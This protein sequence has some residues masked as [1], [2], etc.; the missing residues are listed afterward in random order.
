MAEPSPKNATPSTFRPYVAPGVIMPEFTTRAV[1]LGAILGV[2]FGAVS[3][4]LAL[5]A[6]LTVSASIPVAVLS[7][8]I[9]KWLGKST[10]L[11]NNMVQTV[12]S[13]GESIA[14]GVAFTLPALIFLGFQLDYWNVFLLALAGGL[15]G[16]LFVVPLR[17][18]LVVKEH[19]NLLFPEGKA[20]ADV[21]ISGEEKG[22]QAGKVFIGAGLGLVYKF[23]MGETGGLSFW[24]A[25]P[26][27]HPRWY[28]GSTLAGEITPEYLGVGYIIGP[29][30][31][32][33]MFAGGVISWLVLIPIIKFFG[34]HIPEAIYPGTVPISQM[35]PLDVWRAY[36][37]YIGAGAVTMAG[38]ITLGRTLPTIVGSFRAAFKQLAQSRRGAVVSAERTERDLPLSAVLI[39]T[40]I[41]IV[42]VWALLAFHINPGAHGN[43]VS[44]ILIV[45]F[46]FFFA[47]V[48]ARIVG[49]IGSSS[50][51]VSGMTI[52]TLMFTCLIFVVVGWTGNVYSSIALSI[53]GVICIAAACAGAT[54]QS[55]KTGYLVGGTPSRQEIG[56]L[57]GVLTSVL[58]VGVTLKL[59]NKSAT[60]VNPMT[61]ANVTVTPDMKPQG[62]INYQ[63]REFQVL[64]VIG[65]RTVP[66]GRYYYDPQNR[67]IDYQEVEGI[68]SLDYPAPQATLMSVVINGILNRRLPWSLVLF[69]AFIV[70]TLELCGVRSLAFAVGSYLPISTTAPIFTGGLVKWLVQRVTKTT[71]EES[72]TGAGALFS[73]GLIAGGALGGLALA[74]VVGLKKAEAVAV[75][76]RWFPAFA[77]S[78]LAALL[79][80]VGLATLLFF[81]AKSKKP[82]TK[83]KQ[84]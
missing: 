20:C 69:G 12:G 63:G 17:P 23:L 61:I 75:G 42:M 49:L 11:E 21:L 79:I 8:S 27:W 45:I 40:G 48:S 24:K 41:M 74:V 32:G 36:I 38:L 59:L 25:Q 37:R 77:N 18:P 62:Q 83:E 65:S 13:A 55:L 26:E 19:G 28:P 60:H 56:F 81:M 58:V 82:A 43:V 2:I 10:I 22:I 68:G 80:F 4:Y 76:P 72:E 34:A 29:K 67:Q 64:S 1:A 9:F 46:G 14:A 54:V 47:T 84:S 31:A 39:G 30:V 3:V 51:P 70:V 71:E 53:G 16:A 5:K 78:D 7:V 57:V 33:T 52:A 44:S 66:D 35:S 15:L 50:N 73:S 6:G